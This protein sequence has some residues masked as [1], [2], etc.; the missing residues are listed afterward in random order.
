MSKE[1]FCLK[2]YVAEISSKYKSDLATTLKAI[3]YDLAFLITRAKK[4]Q[5]FKLSE[6]LEKMKQLA[7]AYQKMS[8]DKPLKEK[9]LKQH[10]DKFVA[11]LQATNLEDLAERA[12][13]IKFIQADE[14]LSKIADKA[15]KKRMQS[16]A[17]YMESLAKY[18]NRLE[19]D[20]PLLIGKAKKAKLKELIALL[21]K[22]MEFKSLHKQITDLHR[23]LEECEDRLIRQLQAIDLMKAK[24]LNIDQLVKMMTAVQ[25]NKNVE[26]RNKNMLKLKDYLIVAD[27]DL[28]LL[29]EEAKEAEQEEL[30]K[31]FVITIEL[32]NACRK[33]FSWEKIVRDSEDE[34][35][36]RLEVINWIDLEEQARKIRFMNIDELVKHVIDLIQMSM[37]EYRDCLVAI[38]EEIDID[39]ELSLK[40]A[41]K[42]QL[43]VLVRLLE[44]VKELAD[45]YKFPTSPFETKACENKLI[46]HL[47]H[48]DLNDLVKQAIGTN[49]DKLL[50]KMADA[51]HTHEVKLQDKLATCLKSVDFDLI[52]KVE[53]DGMIYEKMVELKNAYEQMSQEN[54]H[55]KECEETL[56]HD[57][58]HVDLE[59]LLHDLNHVDLRAL[60]YKFQYI[61]A[62][63]LL[64][65]IKNAKQIH[66]A[67][68]IAQNIGRELVISLID[69]ELD[70]K[71]LVEKAKEAKQVKLCE[72]LEKMVEA[73]NKISIKDKRARQ[74]ELSIEVTHLGELVIQAREI[75]SVNID[76][77][78]SRISSAKCTYNEDYAK[79]LHFALGGLRHYEKKIAA[80]ITDLSLL[81]TLAQ[82]AQSLGLIPEKEKN[83]L[84]SLHCSVPCSLIY[85]YLIPHVYIAIEK[86]KD[87]HIIDHWLSI[88]SK[89]RGISGTLDEMKFYFE[90]SVTTAIFSMDLTEEETEHST[91]IYFEGKHI[92]FLTEVLASH[93][94][95]WREIA[96]SLN[97]PE[98]E[99]STIVSMMHSYE[100]VVICL[101]KVLH[102][103]VTKKHEQTKPPTLENLKSAL[104][105]RTVGLGGA[106]HNLQEKIMEAGIIPSGDRVSYERALSIE[107]VKTFKI[108]EQSHST[109]VTEGDSTVL[110]GV[111]ISLPS[112]TP[113]KYQ[114]YKDE[115]ILVDNIR[116][117]KCYGSQQS[118][119]CIFIHNL[120][121]EGSYKCKIHHGEDVIP[122]NPV[123]LTVETPLDPYREKLN[124]FYTAK[125]EVPK[126][127]W[128][129]ANIDSY[130]NLALVKQ[131]GIDN[132]GDYAR[133]TIRGDADDVFKDKEK[134]EYEKAFDEV[135]SGTL[136][137]IEG[138]PGSG[139]T[140]L[141]HKVS[142]DWAEGK[143]K[144]GHV[145][146]LFLVHLRGFL[147]NPNIK[148]QNILECY[149][150]VENDSG[151]GDIVKYASKHNGLGLCF[152]LDG[153]DEYLPKKRDTYIHR[154]INKSQ[155]P[156]AVVIVASRPVSVA[157]F[158]PLATRQ[159]EVLGFLKEQ[160]AEYINVYKFSDESKCTELLKYLDLHGSAA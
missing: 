27:L 10:E 118:I 100:T 140:T 124:D 2:N 86:E 121:V 20:I 51:K 157:D 134:I 45:V 150:D 42:S 41:K 91:D 135:T 31:L 128:P 3:D 145:R 59:T 122:S 156:K 72:L 105:S 40:G 147:S 68:D 32:V 132:A 112:D 30:S 23:T 125:P 111:K 84:T 119:I 153:F 74:E 22:V 9:A 26:G 97:L 113:L 47:Q 149:F 33:V 49:A 99:V 158:R 54:P 62:Y 48:L 129:P 34:F 154:L 120:T 146:L 81:K 110:L 77:V 103:W 136:L 107:D 88:L 160:I 64:K 138:R 114:W 43:V 133:C 8:S 61:N 142:K 24:F 12:G 109:T 15:D 63:D 11:Y 152:I 70:L 19:L 82:E 98:N 85:R 17:R 28:I 89:C 95:L 126:D 46:D 50:S 16:I 141:V 92:Q 75:R 137:L 106:A 60:D 93:S 4:A 101:N 69:F 44:E 143:L 14:L 39:L 155:L 36:L 102:A 108:V 71:R 123:V 29:S 58:N 53:Q 56:L 1:A 151:F 115:K 66:E 144:F 104:R 94:N 21:E 13:K 55:M 87:H 90:K 6:L 139:K 5:H 25:D 131:Q 38:L 7:H 67:D 127:T 130:I 80:N 65:K 37:T 73:E 79:L 159:I 18:F 117:H 57:L 78:V 35:I 96:I 76:E 52:E 83:I 116:D 148:L